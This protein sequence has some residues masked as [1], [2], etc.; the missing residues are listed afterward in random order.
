MVKFDKE[1]NNN[2]TTQSREFFGTGIITHRIM[3][4]ENA[5]LNEV[6]LRFL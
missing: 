1:I 4:F 6:R 3:D 2:N 5:H